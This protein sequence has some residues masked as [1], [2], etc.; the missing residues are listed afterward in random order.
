M[1]TCL[2]ALAAI[3]VA[4]PLAAQ[5][6][7]GVRG[8]MTLSTLVASEEEEWFEVSYLTGFHAGVTA[9][10]GSS[11]AGLLLSAAYAQR[12]SA[13]TVGLPG[14]DPGGSNERSIDVDLAYIDLGAF[15]RI[16]LGAGP[17]LLVGPTLGLRIACS[18]TVSGP[19]GTHVTTGCG[20]GPDEDPYKTFDVGVSGGAG[21][22]FG[23][24]GLGVVVEAL[25]GFGVLNLVDGDDESVRSRGFT[26]R[27][28]LDFGR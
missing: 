28:G 4:A 7:F 19:Q 24:G 8:G 20:E 21:A 27:A 22:S 26:I 17:Y 11:G 16:P 13:I 1:R 25:Y 18:I 9:S 3:A 10:L 23:V 6:S 5:T 15:G 14:P 2:A 12:G